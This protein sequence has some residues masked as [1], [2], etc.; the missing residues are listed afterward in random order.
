MLS[1]LNSSFCR[2]NGDDGS[3][4]VPQAND[5]KQWYR[6]L[7][8]LQKPLFICSGDL[9]LAI[10]SSIILGL[11]QSINDVKPNGDVGF[12]ALVVKAIWQSGNRIWIAWGLSNHILLRAIK[13]RHDYVL[14]EQ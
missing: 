2:S 3:R 13:R 4:S 6:Q 14:Y 9:C 12:T 11:L 8:L 10:A 1:Y 7:Y 5:E